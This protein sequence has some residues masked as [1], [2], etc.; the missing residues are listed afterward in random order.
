MAPS[1]PVKFWRPCQL[2][3]EGQTGIPGLGLVEALSDSTVK[4]LFVG[5]VL[6]SGAP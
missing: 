1:I 2:S 3:A 5:A 6:L 4:I